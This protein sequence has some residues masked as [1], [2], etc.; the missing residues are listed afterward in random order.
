MWSLLSAITISY[1]SDY[2]GAEKEFSRVALRLNDVTSFRR[3]LAR[4]LL[5][6][7]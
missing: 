1:D 2:A 6:V 4:G 7:V 3:S 5:V